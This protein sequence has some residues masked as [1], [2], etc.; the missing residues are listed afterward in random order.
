LTPPSA[1]GERN[2]PRQATRHPIITT[3]QDKFGSTEV[4]L[5]HFSPEELLGLSFLYDTEDGQK[6]RAKVVS[7][8]M[9]KER[10]NHKNIQFLLDLGDEQLQELILYN[11]LSDLIKDQHRME[12]MGEMEIFT[13]REVL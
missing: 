4:R 9:N 6:V 11:E 3:V 5:P 7:Q 13:F 1:E 2:S 12:E 8:V 10:E